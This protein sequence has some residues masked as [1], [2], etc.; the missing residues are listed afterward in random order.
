MYPEFKYYQKGIYR[1]NSTFVQ[2]LVKTEN[3]PDPHYEA[4]NHAVLLVGWGVENGVK[5][6]K[7]MNSWGETWGERGFFRIVR[8]ENNC[9]V[10]FK[11]EEATILPKWAGKRN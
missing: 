11:A 7:I 6:W 2:Q 1:H 9:H 3:K 10:E 8:G 4:T 5:F